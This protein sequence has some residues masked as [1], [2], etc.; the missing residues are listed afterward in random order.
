M[1]HDASKPAYAQVIPLEEPSDEDK[2]RLTRSRKWRL[3]VPY[4]KNPPDPSTKGY[5]ETLRIRV[6]KEFDPE[7]D[8]IRRQRNSETKAER[9]RNKKLGIKRTGMKK[10][11]S[12]LGKIL[13]R[14]E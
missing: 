2:L 7:Y 8:Q 4:L 1:Q 13:P 9:K 11:E 5:S 14:P 10:V 12:I 3:L 6:M